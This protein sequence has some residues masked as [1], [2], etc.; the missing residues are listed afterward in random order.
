LVNRQAPARAR[1]DLKEYLGI[2]ALFDKSLYV[3]SPEKRDIREKRSIMLRKKIIMVA[4]LCL[5][6]SP[7]MA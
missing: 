6:A 4:L 1:A 3:F 2:D 5:I 7:L